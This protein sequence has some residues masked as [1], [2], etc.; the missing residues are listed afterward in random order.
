MK[1]TSVPGIVGRTCCATAMALQ[2][3]NYLPWTALIQPY[4]KN[5]D[6]LI[7]PDQTDQAFIKAANPIARKELYSGY[8][9]NYGYLTTFNGTCANTGQYSFPGISLA[10]VKRAANT[11]LLVDTVGLNYASRSAGTVWTPVGTTVEPPIDCYAFARSTT[12]CDAFSDGWTGTTDSLTAGYDFPGYGG[13]SFRHAGGSWKD[14]TLPDGGT[15]VAFCD[16]HAK[17]FKAG[18]LL[19]GTNFDPTKGG[20]AKVTDTSAYMWDPNN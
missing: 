16:G 17:F 6:L 18:A 4:E 10:Q 1:P 8:G 3:R 9:L 13:A 19:A 5:T 2:Y 7:C 15:N 20:G 14:K 12:D 11:V